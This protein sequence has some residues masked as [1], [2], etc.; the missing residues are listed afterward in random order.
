MTGN[1]G[2][3]AAAVGEPGHVA[4]PDGRVVVIGVGNEFR[5]D[6]GVAHAVLARLRGRVPHGVELVTSDGEPTAIIEAWH[7]ASVAVVIDTARA[8]PAVPGRVHRV[9]VNRAGLASGAPVSSHGFGLAAA[10][11]LGTALGRFPVR[12]IVHVVEAGDLSQGVGLTP[13]VAAAVDALAA[14]VLSDVAS[15]GRVAVRK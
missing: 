13:A 1:E 4:Q 10:V 9:D 5:H 2:P 8:V 15:A 11:A 14:A 12:L 3:G 7:E 6:D